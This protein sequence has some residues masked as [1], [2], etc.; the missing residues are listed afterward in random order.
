VQFGHRLT[1]V[2]LPAGLPDPDEIEAELLGYCDVLLG[3]VEP[4]VASP[5][6]SLA[7]VATAYYARAQE[8]TMLIHCG[9]REGSIPRGHPYYRVRVGALRD[10][11]ELSKEMAGL[12]S[13]RLTQEQ[14]LRQQ[15]L[16]QGEAL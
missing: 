10:F 12:G 9:E 5:Y 7:E 11:I 13:R 1:V 14:L 2:P 8:L 4:P 15:R 6:L 3:R 16:D